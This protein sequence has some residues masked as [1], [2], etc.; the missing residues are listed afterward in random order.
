[1]TD[2]AFAL[3]WIAQEYDFWMSTVRD[4][5][6][7]LSLLKVLPDHTESVLDVGCG[8]GQ[9]ALYLADFVGHVTGLDISHAMI[10]RAKA[11]QAA[12][13]KENVAFA[14][15]DLAAYKT[16][17]RG[18]DFVVSDYALHNMSLT[19]VLPILQRLVR[20]GGRLFVRDLV[21]TAPQQWRS[22]RWQRQRVLQEAP[23]L[24]RTH[25]WRA[26]E[27]ILRFR[28][29]SAW[30]KH[31]CTDD[32]V[33]A[34][35]AQ[36]LYQQFLPTCS[37]R[38]QGHELT[39]LWQAPAPSQGLDL[40]QPGEVIPDIYVT[41]PRLQPP[42]PWREERFSKA[43]IE[44]SIVQIFEKQVAQYPQRMAVRA[45]TV[46]TYAELNAAANRLAHEL[47]QRRGSASEPVA[48]VVGR[49]SATLIALLGILKAGKA[50]VALDPQQP[51]ERLCQ[52]V[53]DAQAS[54]LVTDDAHLAFAAAVAA[55]ANILVN[56]EQ[57]SADLAD[58]NLNLPLTADHLA[59]IFYTSGS[60]GEA[61][62]IT[63]DHR[64][65]LHSTWH[66]TNAYAIT[67]ADRHSLLGF[68]GHTAT[69]P[70]IYDTLLN[71][72][73]LCLFD[74]RPH[75]LS[76]LADWLIQEEITLFHPPVALFRNLLTSLHGAQNAPHLRMV[77][78]AG[79]TVHPK[80]VE[81]FRYH[82]PSH[83]ILL[84]RLASTEAGSVAHLLIDQQTPIGDCVPVGFPTADKEILILDEHGQPLPKGEVGEIAIR[85]RYLST[86]YWQ[87]PEA[88]AAKFVPDPLDAQLRLYLTGDLGQLTLEGALQHLGRKDLLVKIR[89]F[90][91][92]LEEVE[93][94]LLTLPA[95]QQAAV[96]VYRPA[97]AEPR[98][99]GYV[100]PKPEQTLTTDQLR[101]HLL[102]SLPDYMIPTAWLFLATLPITTT[103]KVDR[104][105]LPQ[106]T[107]TRPDVETPFVAPRNALEEQIADI[108]SELLELDRV[109]ID[110]NF[111]ELGGD[112]LTLLRMTLTVEQKLKGSIPTPYY[113][114]PTIRHM[115]QIM[116][117]ESPVIPAFDG[118]NLIGPRQPLDRERYHPNGSFP[119]RLANAFWGR[120]PFYR[121]LGLPYPIGVYLQ[122]SLLCQ[123]M[124]QTKFFHQQSMLFQQCLVD[125]GLSRPHNDQLTLH[126]MAN[127][128]K[129]WRTQALSSP[130]AFAHWV[131]W[132]G[133]DQLETMVKKGNG[134]IIVFTHQI[135]AVKFTQRLLLNHNIKDVPVI[136]GKG[137]NPYGLS[138][139]AQRTQSARSAF[140]LLQ[141]G[142]AVLVA[143]DGLGATN[144]I[145]VAFYGRQLLIPRGFAELALLSQASVCATFLSMSTN[146][147]IT[148]EFVP[149]PTPTSP[150]EADDVLFRYIDL[151]VER[152]PKLLPT[153]VWGRV[154]YL[155]S[156]PTTFRKNELSL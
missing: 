86:G 45:E 147:R 132:Q 40:P 143:G 142:G 114:L 120:G 124:I 79:Q 82:F 78:L 76:D 118:A 92:Q 99:V 153:M 131:T 12:Q 27:R 134:L 121:G 24:Y 72:A 60:S 33:T 144:A 85:S 58:E 49:G 148:V 25:G 128:W 80:D 63:R 1:M 30:I 11:Y 156:L 87:K 90:R 52:L 23:T 151:L 95:I 145:P 107:F 17:S 37:I 96:S 41:Q 26:T 73:T 47:V 149:L 35:D 146:G 32:V 110:D 16:D 139:E 152:W 98:L 64:Q 111:F 65:I 48:I 56:L 4:S 38:L 36:Q 113:R 7:Y 2:A 42:R 61:K 46:L 137:D 34:A 5:A 138:R 29:S 103:G 39:V 10:E 123:S 21:S 51:Q 122:H 115:T 119:S 69:V 84:H 6:H 108:W 129:A 13:Q 101:R 66:N 154:K 100:V 94:A 88:T 135:F 116:N 28:L 19:Q 89:G 31:V 150:K 130:S 14:V 97:T 127:N 57:L 15:G 105:A 62:G 18:F 70:D 133:A 59:G 117:G 81:Q 50:Y 55:D 125:A 3:D 102:R 44:S 155:T 93:A 104:Q 20:P 77:I 91:V 136:S 83:C 109:G 112:S 67:A 141:H 74:P 71:G 126:L 140:E 53:V 43:N 8:T 54:L 22:T 106:P 75:S 68:C 9:L